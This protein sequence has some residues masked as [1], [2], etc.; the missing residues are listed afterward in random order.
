MSH[1]DDNKYRVRL[2]SHGINLG[3]KARTRFETIKSIAGW[4]KLDG[5]V[6]SKIKFCQR[7]IS[8]THRKTL[9][10]CAELWNELDR[11]EKEVKDR[12]P[13]KNI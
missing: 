7:N 5:R 10:G 9:L 13:K 8:P 1:F 6:S 4:L 3:T 2:S 12:S 11:M